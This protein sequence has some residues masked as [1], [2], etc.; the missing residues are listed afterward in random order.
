MKT[1]NFLVIEAGDI[2]YKVFAPADVLLKTK[3][4]DEVALFTHQHV[5]EDAIQLFGFLKFEELNLFEQLISVSGIGP[6]T[7]LAVFAEAKLE[8]IISA[9]VNGDA[10]IL[11]RVSGIGSKTAERIVLELKNKIAAGAAIENIK[12]G[13]ELGAD[14]D[15]VEAL[16][17]LGY[18]VSQSR[19]ALKR[20]SVEITDA[21]EK[22]REAL[23][24]I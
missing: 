18:S 20:V 2:G 22:V 21:G 23:K 11:K 7:A 4:D 6:K 13:Q 24:N 5:R 1:G 14:A 15:A 8:D 10:S 16:V 19:E 12:T 9:I 17:S 3:Q